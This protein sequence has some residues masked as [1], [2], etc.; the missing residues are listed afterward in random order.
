MSLLLI[1]FPFSCPLGHLWPQGSL[2]TGFLIQSSSSTMTL[3]SFSGIVNRNYPKWGL[4]KL[5]EGLPPN[6]PWTLVR[7]LMKICR[8]TRW[9]YKTVHLKCFSCAVS[10]LSG[11]EMSEYAC[12]S[13]ALMNGEQNWIV[14][15]NDFRAVLSSGAGHPLVVTTLSG[16][17]DMLPLW[18]TLPN[19]TSGCSSLHFSLRSVMPYSLNLCSTARSL[20]SCSLPTPCAQTSS[21]ICTVLSNPSSILRSLAWHYAE[22]ACAPMTSLLNR[23]SP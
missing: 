4:K 20:L 10:C 19:I 17:G 8:V 13:P 5:T 18:N 2:T 1:H 21:L 7:Y 22:A 12:P 11:A 16:S 14:C 23:N 15:R 3:Y 9:S 6:C